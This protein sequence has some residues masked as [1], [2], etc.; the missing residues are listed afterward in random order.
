RFWTQKGVTR[1]KEFIVAIERRLR[2]NPLVSV[3]V[4]RNTKL[5]SGIEDSRHGPNDAMHN[6]SLATQGYELAVDDEFLKCL[7]L[8][9]CR[10]TTLT[11][12]ILKLEMLSMRSVNEILYKLNIPD[13]RKLKDGGEERA[14][15]YY[16]CKE[17]FK[18][19]VR[20]WVRSKSI[21]A[22][23]LEKVV[24]HLIDHA[25]KGFAAASAVLKL[26]RLKVDKHGMSEPISYYLI[27]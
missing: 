24:T 13:H 3:E 12:S 26:E 23:W 27:D 9:M 2:D 21:T 6:P 22:I 11:D 1:S 16:E 15:V 8:S 25:I 17:P 18:S 4:L 19:L 10:K 5:L 14:E 20:L 7:T